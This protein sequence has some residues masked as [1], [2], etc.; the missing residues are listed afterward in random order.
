MDA[1]GRAPSP[2]QSVD[3]SCL[4]LLDQ[5]VADQKGIVNVAVDTAGETITFAYDPRRV[6]EDDILRMAHNVAPALQQRWETC[7]LRLEKRGGRA[8]ESC[9][10]ALERQVGQLPG[11]RR[12]TASFN[13]GVMACPL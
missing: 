7:T 11:V 4:E 3:P 12:A 1:E 5:A 10:L 6:E 13:G 9:A 8:C 2:D